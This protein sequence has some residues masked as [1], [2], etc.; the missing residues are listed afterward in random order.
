MFEDPYVLVSKVWERWIHTPSKMINH[1]YKKYLL[2]VASLKSIYIYMGD[3][4]IA[5]N[6]IQC[7]H[8]TV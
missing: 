3:N 6:K 7:L 4:Q 1:N 2:N 5:M 8:L